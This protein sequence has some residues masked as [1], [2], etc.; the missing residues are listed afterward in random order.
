MIARH[1][2]SETATRALLAAAPSPMGMMAEADDVAELIAFLVIGRARLL[3]GQL[4]F[5]DGGLDALRR[6]TTTLD[7]L[8]STDSGQRPP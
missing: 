2:T 6:P 3:T 7:A 8:P 5:V 4:I 1:L